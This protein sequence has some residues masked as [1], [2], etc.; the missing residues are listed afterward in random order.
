[1][2]KTDGLECEPGARLRRASVVDEQRKQDLTDLCESC[3]PLLTHS[4]G[5]R[6]RPPG[7]HPHGSPWPSMVR[8]LEPKALNVKLD[9]S[10][11]R[12]ANLCGPGIVQPCYIDDNVVEI[13]DCGAAAVSG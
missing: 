9:E 11:R 10:E 3:F 7:S 6:R 1:M 5:R 2:R 12:R 8:L 4:T 13:I